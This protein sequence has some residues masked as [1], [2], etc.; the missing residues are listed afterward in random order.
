MN[1]ILERAARAI[2]IAYG[3]DPDE[4]P[5]PVLN[6]THYAKVTRAILTAIREPSLEMLEAGCNAHPEGDYHSGTM[7][8]DII[9]AEWKAMIDKVLE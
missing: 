7:L 4:V 5:I 2:C 3:H 1:E 8:T 9:E 6:Q